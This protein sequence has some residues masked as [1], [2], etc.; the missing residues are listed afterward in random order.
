MKHEITEL[1]L[2]FQYAKCQINNYLLLLFICCDV[3]IQKVSMLKLWS[4]IR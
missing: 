3:G 1:L 2:W 4:Q